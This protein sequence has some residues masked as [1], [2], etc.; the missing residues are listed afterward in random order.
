MNQISGGASCPPDLACLS[1]TFESND[2]QASCYQDVWQSSMHI[3]AA[4][5]CRHSPPRGLVLAHIN[6]TGQHVPGGAL[7]GSTTGGI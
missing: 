2:R 3:E 7:P 1:P 5:S 4:G 6:P